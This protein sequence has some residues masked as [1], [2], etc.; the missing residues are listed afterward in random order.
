MQDIKD[1]VTHSLYISLV[2]AP[3]WVHRAIGQQKDRQF[4]QQAFEALSERLAEA[5]MRYEVAQ[6]KVDMRCPFPHIGG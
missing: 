5:M 3:A 2:T 1:D 6:R 4:R